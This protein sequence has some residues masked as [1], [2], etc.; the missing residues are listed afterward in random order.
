MD[1]L[2]VL[3]GSPRQI[4]W[5]EEI[6]RVKI[7]QG[8]AFING[9]RETTERLAASLTPGIFDQRKRTLEKMIISFE[10]IKRKPEARWWIDN[11]EE[12]ISELI[13]QRIVW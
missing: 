9:Y 13:Q 6:R 2:L 4:E 1:E 11:R 5:A 8:E 3:L 10:F 7:K 12:L